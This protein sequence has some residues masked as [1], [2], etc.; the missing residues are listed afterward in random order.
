MI[1]KIIHYCWF[2]NAEIPKQH[3]RYIE[4]WKKKM[5]D[6]EFMLWN[7][8][9]SPM[10]LPYMQNALKNK[11]W[12]NLSNYSRL[13]ALNQYGG[14]YLDTDI[15]LL[16]S[17]TPLLAN[18]CFFGFEDP[19]MD[20]EGCVN[21]AVMGAMP[22]HWFV[23]HMMSSLLE[24]FDGNESAHLSSPNLTTA[25][26]KQEG[27]KVYGEQS[28]KDIKIFPTEYF[29]PYSWH[30]IFNPD[31]VTQNT[32]CIHR[33]AQSWSGKPQNIVYKQKLKKF[34]HSIRWQ[35]KKQFLPIR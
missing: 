13:H 31:N 15:E 5:P 7:E 14:I 23:K 22:E 20:W 9:N 6:Y 30:Q 19:Y 32:Y 35:L 28:L 33:F 2:G 34:Y 18:S 10:H 21:N 26:L 24:C 25:L 4:D 29:Y 1:P 11:K 27:L 12:A 16:K 3:K 8:Q 17:F